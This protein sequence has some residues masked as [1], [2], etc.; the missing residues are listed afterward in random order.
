MVTDAP[1]QGLFLG[2]TKGRKFVCAD[3]VKPFGNS[4]K[5]IRKWP[6]DLAVGLGQVSPIR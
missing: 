1:S 6:V 5:G 3:A 4:Q 2:I